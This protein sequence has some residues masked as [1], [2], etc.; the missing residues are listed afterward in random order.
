MTNIN[1]T[2]AA[3]VHI[4]ISNDVLIL[5]LLSERIYKWDYNNDLRLQIHFT[6]K[7]HSMRPRWPIRTLLLQMQGMWVGEWVGKGHGAGWVST[8][9]AHINHLWLMDGWNS[10]VRQEYFDGSCVR[11]TVRVQKYSTETGTTRQA[12]RQTRGLTAVSRWSSS[13]SSSSLNYTKS[14]T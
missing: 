7:F 10:L 13:S 9:C 14:E 1:V 5:N 8:Q 4:S 3:V 2:F 6:S 11:M 12:D